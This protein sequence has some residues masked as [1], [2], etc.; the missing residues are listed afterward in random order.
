MNRG[1][2]RILVFVVIFIS[3]LALDPAAF[4][5]C[6]HFLPDEF[7]DIL[8]S[9][10]K[11]DTLVEAQGIIPVR[12]IDC[13]GQL[14]IIVFCSGRY[15]H[16]LEQVLPVW[17]IIKTVRKGVGDLEPYA[18]GAA[19]GNTPCPLALLSGSSNRTSPISLAPVLRI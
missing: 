3:L 12:R 1:K 4:A 7:L 13:Q 11:E 18:H 6:T 16:V 15:F 17:G 5:R 10:Q 8:I 9:S 2:K 19:I 14:L